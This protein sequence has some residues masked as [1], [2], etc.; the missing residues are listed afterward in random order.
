VE[1]EMIDGVVQLSIHDDGVGG[2]DPR[3]GSG[4]VGLRDRVES[5]GGTIAIE[6]PAGG[7]TTLIAKLP[8]ED[9]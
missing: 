3:Q 8:V 7:G 6:S 5:L 9:I 2:A 1:V 4:L